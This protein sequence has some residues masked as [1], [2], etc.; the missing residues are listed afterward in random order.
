MYLHKLE[1]PKGL[2]GKK[3]IGR[4]DASGWGKTSGRGD[5][6]QKSRSGGG[7]RR[8]FEGGTMPLNRRLPKRGFS[9][10]KFADKKA[11]INIRYIDSFEDGS[12]IGPEEFIAA[13][14]CAPDVIKI[15]IIGTTKLTKAITVKAHAFTKGAAQSIKDAKGTPLTI[16]KESIRD[17]NATAEEISLDK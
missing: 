13:E 7:V 5:K 17:T 12:T 8:G 9:N 2:K 16:S 3:R 1:K 11:E 10:Q 15:K 4:G 6:G 14:L